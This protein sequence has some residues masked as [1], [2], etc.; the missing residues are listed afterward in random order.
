MY[1]V[2]STGIFF[3]AIKSISFQLDFVMFFHDEFLLKIVDTPL[4]AIA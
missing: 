4:R 3:L 1:S 2:G